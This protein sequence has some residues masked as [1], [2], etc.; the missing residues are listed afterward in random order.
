[1]IE[2]IVAATL[3]AILVLWMLGALLFCILGGALILWVL[4]LF[5]VELTR[6]ILE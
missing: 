1:M 6:D 3:M 2:T 5:S 4:F